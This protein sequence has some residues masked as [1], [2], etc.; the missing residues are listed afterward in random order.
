[1]I[2]E[3]LDQLGQAKQFTQLD[4]MSSYHRMRIKEGNEWKTAFGA[5]YG[6]FEYQVM[7]LGLSNAPTSFW[8]YIYKI[9]AE[10]LDIFVNIY[11]VDIF[12][13]TEDPGQT[14]VDA[15]QW[16]LKELRKNGLFA[17]LKKCYFH[18]DEIHF[19]GYVASAQGVKIKKKRIDVVKN[20]PR[21]KSIHDI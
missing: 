21:A 15:V 12:I 6:H 1:M 7:P 9:F 14:Y 11:L 20:W 5:Q 16:V 3:S 17:N 18:K 19:L 4:L 2:G 13:Y 8:G 10:K